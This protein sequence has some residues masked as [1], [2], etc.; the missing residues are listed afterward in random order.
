[1]S[2]SL[3]TY[4]HGGLP[5]FFAFPDGL[6]GYDCD[7]CGAWCCLGVGSL[8][9]LRS[10]I[11]GL[12]KDYFKPLV[13]GVRGGVLRV[14][15]GLDGCPALAVSGRCLIHVERGRR[16]KPIT[17]ALYPFNVLVRT[18]RFCAVVPNYR[19]VCP[20]VLDPPSDFAKSH[21]SEIADDLA[22]FLGDSLE[23]FEL[24]STPE[25]NGV[26]YDTEQRVLDVVNDVR[27]RYTLAAALSKASGGSESALLERAVKALGTMGLELVPENSASMD[28]LLFMVPA[29]RTSFYHLRLAEIDAALL[30]GW[31][32]V[33]AAASPAQTPTLR[34]IASVFTQV[35][36]LVGLVVQADRLV[37]LDG[38]LRRPPGG[39]PD[40]AL[41]VALVLRDAKR[42]PWK[43]TLSELLSRHVRAEGVQRTLV[44]RELSRAGLE[45]KGDR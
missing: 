3:P 28:R 26:S 13:S 14:D 33:L 11:D 25:L 39:D 16:S 5:L 44:V 31:R 41:E 23:L 22:Y 7:S 40:V 4:R 34:R 21:Y 15:I 32:F 10:Q 12:G 37:R 20:L 17:C 9:V 45:F 18:Q 35:S 29:L 2:S 8:T 19:Y 27:G 43:Y 42:D 36:K 38:A 1:M 6:I 24:V 30:V